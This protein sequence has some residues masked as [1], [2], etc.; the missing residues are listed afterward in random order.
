MFHTFNHCIPESNESA[1]PKNISTVLWGGGGVKNYMPCDTLT[2]SLL[3]NIL[4]VW[5]PV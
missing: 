3:N 4:V 5:F 1:L 2:Y